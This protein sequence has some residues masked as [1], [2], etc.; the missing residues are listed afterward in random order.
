MIVNPVSGGRRGL[1]VLHQALPAFHDAGIEPEVIVTRAGHEPR[2]LARKA[3]TE[4]REIVVAVGGDGLTAAVAEGLVGTDAVLAVLPAGSSNDYARSLEMPR[5]DVRAAVA[6][7]ARADTR[8]VDVISVRTGD[9]ERIF[10]NVVGTGFDAAVAATAEQIPVMRGTGRYVLAIMR[11]LRRFSA[12]SF[13]MVIDGESHRQRA[14]MIAL[15]NGHSYGGGMRIAPQAK[16]DSGWLEICIVGEVSKRQFIRTF[17][18]VFSGTHVDHPA[19]TMLRGR[20][21]AISA[22]RPLDLMGD[23]ERIGRLPATVTVIPAALSVVI[24]TPSG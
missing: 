2:Q 19:V 4:G 3:A 12:A 1:R 6:A 22:D 5:R 18:R 11:E 16:L 10:L 14:M 15:A 7:I 13:E 23:G 8:R 17:P 24:G 20:S 21:I 9:G